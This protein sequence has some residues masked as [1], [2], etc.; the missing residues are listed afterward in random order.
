MDGPLYILRDDR[1]QFS[2]K[3]IIFF[4]LKIYFILANSADPDEMPHNV[5]FH[6]GHHCLPKYLIRG[7][8]SIYKGLTYSCFRPQDKS[9][10]QK[11]IFLISH[12][13]Y[14]LGTQKKRLDEMVLLSTQNICLN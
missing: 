5:A 10:Y 8:S 9:V 1:L 4:S 6:L 7:F 12:Q 3:K 14:V 11:I 2:K 13:T